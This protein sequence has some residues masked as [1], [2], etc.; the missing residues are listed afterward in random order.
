MGKMLHIS[1]KEAA[2]ML[3]QKNGK[4]PTA[5][6]VGKIVQYFLSPKSRRIVPGLLK[7]FERNPKL[8]NGKKTYAIARRGRIP[9]VM[10]PLI[11]LFLNQGFKLPDWYQTKSSPR[12]LKKNQA[13]AQVRDNAIHAW[14][15]R[16]RK[17]FGAILAVLE[18]RHETR[19]QDFDQNTIDCEVVEP[20][21]SNNVVALPVTRLL[22]MPAAA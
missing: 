11:Q 20:V 12:L 22:I 2:L 21:E 1:R 10:I 3:V 18:Q 7:Y 13:I 16:N 19:P 6:T 4:H 17:Q 5:K 14:I 9:A 8:P 15:F